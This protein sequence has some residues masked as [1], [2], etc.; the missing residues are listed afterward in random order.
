MLKFPNIDPVALQLGPL[1]IHWYGLCYLIGFALVY[2]LGRL[3]A[4]RVPKLGFHPD[5][6]S[7]LVFYGALGVIIGGR[8]GYVFF[9]GWD[10]LMAD[11]LYLFKMWEGG[12]SFHGGFLATVL[13]LW[14]YASKTNRHF[15]QVTDFII[16]LCPLGIGAVR[17]ANFINGELWGRVTDVPWAMAFPTAPDDLPRHP[18]Q[19]YEAFLEGFIAFIIVWWFARKPRALGAVSALFVLIYGLSRFTVEFFRQPDS[20]MGSDGF[21]A[22]GWLTMGQILTLP[23]IIVGISVLILAHRG[24]FSPKPGPKHTAAK[25]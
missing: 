22:F 11:P 20:H 7:D 3:R 18:S 16:P 10:N 21:I 24:S 4:V 12:M 17:I 14:W 13:L 6:M 25:A 1:K 2:W 15:L 9:Y 8:L 5:E 19:L 23:M